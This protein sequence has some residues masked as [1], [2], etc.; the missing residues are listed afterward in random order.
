MKLWMM[1]GLALVGTLLLEGCAIPSG[2]A[3]QGQ[4]APQS[5]YG[6]KAYGY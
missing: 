6:S 1:M 2:P 5:D 4:P 3:A